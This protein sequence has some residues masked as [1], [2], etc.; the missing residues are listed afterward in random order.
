[1]L[2][3]VLITLVPIVTT[4]VPE[5][6]E[7]SCGRVVWVV[8]HTIYNDKRRKLIVLTATALFATGAAEA[9]TKRRAIKVKSF[10][11]K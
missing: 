1:M 3:S 5:E 11:M 8:A 2:A 4:N 10:M 6:L 7:T 9:L